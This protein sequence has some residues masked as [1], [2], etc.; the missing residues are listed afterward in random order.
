MAVEIVYIG[1]HGIRGTTEERL[2]IPLLWLIIKTFLIFQAFVLHRLLTYLNS[3]DINLGVGLGLVAAISVTELG[4]SLFFGL[5]WQINYRAGNNCD[6]VILISE[7]NN[8][9]KL[10]YFSSIVKQVLTTYLNHSQVCFLEPTST[11]V[12]WGIMVVTCVG[13][14]PMTWSCE[15]DTLSMKTTTPLEK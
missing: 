7:N 15:A 8:E 14:E 4:R 11:G 6:V 9:F 13:F 3:G 12:I 2:Y 10:I 5:T 1:Y